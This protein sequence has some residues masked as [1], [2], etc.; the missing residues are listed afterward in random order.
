MSL[1]VRV[2]LTAYRWELSPRGMKVP[3]E[4]HWLVNPV[5]FFLLL[6]SPS[7]AVA[8]EE[9]SGKRLE[10]EERCLQLEEKAS[11]DSS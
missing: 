5:P 3:V 11:G 4:L 6:K 9:E 10:L 2:K 7:N 1:K 8:V